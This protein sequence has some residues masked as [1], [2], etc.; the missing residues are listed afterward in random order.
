LSEQHDA[1]PARPRRAKAVGASLLVLAALVLLAPACGRLPGQPTPPEADDE[2]ILQP[3]GED[4]FV[5]L[6]SADSADPADPAGSASSSPDRGQDGH[7][8]VPGSA[9][10]PTEPPI[11]AASAGGAGRAPAAD[12]GGPDTAATA[13]LVLLALVS[14]GL[15]GISAASVR[16]SLH[17]WRSIDAVGATGFRAPAGP[18]ASSFSL[19]VVAG[20]AGAAGVGA[21]GR[22]DAGRLGHDA[23]RLGRTLDRLAGIDHPRLEVLAV[24]GHDDEGAREAAGAAAERHPGR[25]R[26]VVD[27]SFR[28]SAG[29][30]LDAALAACRGDVVGVVETGDRVHPGLLAA[31]DATM[32][33]T[34]AVALQGGVRLVEGWSGR[35]PR[36]RWS[37]LRHAV[38]RYL[39]YRSRLHW[40]AERGFVPLSGSTAFVRADTLRSLG[41][42]DPLVTAPGTALGLELS[43]AGLPVAV[44]DD[45]DLATWVEAPATSGEV[46][47]AEAR[48][49]QG[50]IEAARRGA[51]RRLPTRRQR[52]AARAT[53]ARPLVQA[54]GGVVLP[55]ALVAAVALGA[56]WPVLAAL[57]VP[58]VPAVLGVVVEMVGLAELVR[59]SGERVRVRDQLRLVVGA[60]PYRML[61]AVA[62]GRAVVRAR[63]GRRVAAEST[64]DA[65]VAG[66][67]AGAL[68]PRADV[69]ELDLDLD[70]GGRGRDVVDLSSRRRAAE[71]AAALRAG[72]LE[73]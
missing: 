56:P 59:T 22:G 5:V 41:G 19:V 20:L 11:G 36:S 66:V 9:S 4:D 69:P 28:K 42:W 46:V 58:V 30:A 49:I 48:R 47:R 44:A 51:W 15:T 2:P 1:M 33:A 37:T 31:V 53:L 61:L 68:D 17:A 64:A 39:W 63:A 8:P 32:A 25:V 54:A 40:H 45:A 52:L 73:R 38:D 27:R 26:V 3:A 70:P 14:L 65:A 16:R 50:F 13:G 29:S 10:P 7:A 18:P 67:G 62:A 71:A 60:V 21:S 34:G 55:A 35:T 12:P 6:H 24:V 57:L 43:V 23:G 72:A